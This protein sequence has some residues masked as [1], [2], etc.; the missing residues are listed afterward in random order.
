VEIVTGI[1]FKSRK[2]TQDLACFFLVSTKYSI[3]S[4]CGN[5][6]KK[7][8]WHAEFKRFQRIGAR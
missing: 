7:G 5:N 8:R 4:V 3:E 6:M 1:P 2:N